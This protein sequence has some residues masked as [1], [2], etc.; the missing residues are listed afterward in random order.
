[1]KRVNGFSTYCAQSFNVG[2]ICLIAILLLSAAQGALADL[3]APAWFDPDG[4]GSGDDWHYRVP[5]N[6]PTGVF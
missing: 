5:I 6:I 1:M 2:L 4:V 3:R